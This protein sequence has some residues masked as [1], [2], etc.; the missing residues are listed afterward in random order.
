[1]PRR[2]VGNFISVNYGGRDEIMDVRCSNGVG[3]SVVGPGGC[4]NRKQETC[5]TSS[6]EGR[7]RP[8]LLKGDLPKYS[9]SV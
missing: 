3:S 9:L 1:M 2:L 7:N 8:M 6:G 4:C 5:T